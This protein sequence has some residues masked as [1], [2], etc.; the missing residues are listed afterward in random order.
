MSENSV[1]FRAESLGW[2]DDDLIATLV[3]LWDGDRGFEITSYYDSLQGHSYIL[4]CP[5]KMKL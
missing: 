3:E 1:K 2:R 5:R 4:D